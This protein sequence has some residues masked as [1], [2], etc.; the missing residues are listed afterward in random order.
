M[1]ADKL[2]KHPGRDFAGGAWP[3]GRENDM[4]CAALNVF[5]PHL[6]TG[7]G[8]QA[9]IACVVVGAALHLGDG[10]LK[11]VEPHTDDLFGRLPGFLQPPQFLLQIVKN[12]L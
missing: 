5:I 11:L 3:L 1:F 6:G 9:D 10:A 8:I 12:R 4:Q 7:G 2:W